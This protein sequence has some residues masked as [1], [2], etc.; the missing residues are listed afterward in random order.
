[1]L[2][3]EECLKALDYLCKCACELADLKLEDRQSHSQYEVS[4]LNK[5]IEEHFELL[6]KYKELKSYYDNL[7]SCLELVADSLVECLKE[8]DN[9]P[10]KFE[11]LEEM[12]DKPIWDNKK[13]EWFI[14]FELHK[15]FEENRF[16]RKQVEE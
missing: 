10:L 7:D 4:M 9:P 11:E 3:K 16:Y 13:K 14:D 6:G 2:T 1:M 12:I 8:L 5:L 15:K